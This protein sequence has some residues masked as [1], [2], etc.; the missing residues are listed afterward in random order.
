MEA[1][2]RKAEPNPRFP[3]RITVHHDAMHWAG[4]I[5]SRNLSTASAPFEKGILV[6]DGTISVTTLP[7]M[8]EAASGSVGRCNSR[9]RT[10]KARTLEIWAS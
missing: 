8:D 9:A 2:P 10:L 5:L 1:L 3:N 6:E 7:L 4:G